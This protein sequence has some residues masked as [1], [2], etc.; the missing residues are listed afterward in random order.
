MNL[1]SYQRLMNDIRACEE[2]SDKKINSDVYFIVKL[3]LLNE[4]IDITSFIKKDLVAKNIMNVEALS[5]YVYRNT[6]YILF[7]SVEG[8]HYL[9]GSHH[10]LCSH[11]ASN[12]TEYHGCHAISKVIELDN[13]DKVSIYLQA[14][15][16]ENMK[17]TIRRVSNITVSKKETTA[18][19]HAELINLLEQK[20]NIKWD[21]TP[22]AQKYGIF[23]KLCVGKDGT[24]KFSTLSEIINSK[25]IEKLNDFLFT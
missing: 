12:A 7:S 10:A 25:S 18:L 9:D 14:M 21:E 15:V 22:T 3:S 1:S 17:E 11:Y 20:T 13:R 5:A 8:T 19:T 2:N 4:D 6:A 16:T 23:Y 24:K